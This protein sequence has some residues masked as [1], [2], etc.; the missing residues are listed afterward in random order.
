MH[1]DITTTPDT[2]R[3]KIRARLATMPEGWERQTIHNLLE[4][5]EATER[6]HA[7]QNTVLT[8]LRAAAKDTSA[9]N[10][11]LEDLVVRMRAALRVCAGAFRSRAESHQT[12]G[13]DL[14]A[15]VEMDKVEMCE[16]LAKEVV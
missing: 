9:R 6:G 15:R 4:L 3:G 12:A 14:K 1:I 5:L 16:S 10:D 7:I 13:H 2:P 8:H 11:S